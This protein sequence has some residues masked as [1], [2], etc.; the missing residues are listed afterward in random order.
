VKDVTKLRDFVEGTPSTDGQVES[1]ADDFDLLKQSPM[2]GDNKYKLEIALTSPSEELSKPFLS[3]YITSLVMDYAHG[4][5]ESS[6]TMLA[7]IKCQSD[8]IGARGARPEWV[9]E[10]WQN[11]W[12]FRQESEVWG[13]CILSF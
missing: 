1:T 6:A 2:L 9:W 3:L 12:V 8:A 13:M 7:A 10:F 11:D 4:D 5:F